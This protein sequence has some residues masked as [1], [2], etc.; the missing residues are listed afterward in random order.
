MSHMIVVTQHCD[1]TGVR[2][3]VRSQQTFNIVA[4]TCYGMRDCRSATAGADAGSASYGLLIAVAY[5]RGRHISAS[6]VDQLGQLIVTAR[7]FN[8][9]H[10]LA[11]TNKGRCQSRANGVVAACLF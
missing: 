8:I 11:T 7:L 1:V 6:T 4:I 5:D 10:V 9:H 3:A 2:T